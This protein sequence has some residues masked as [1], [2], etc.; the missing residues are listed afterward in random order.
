MNEATGP[1]EPAVSGR[2]GAFTP[3]SP[4]AA[5]G[6]TVAILLLAAA[7]VVAFVFVVAGLQP[8]SPEYSALWIFEH[9]IALFGVWQ[10]IVIL[11]TLWAARWFGGERA[12]VLALGPG[13]P[14]LWTFP[15]ALG[16]MVLV[17]A[18]YNALVYMLSPRSMVADLKP[19][20]ELLQNQDWR[21]LFAVI[22]VGAPLSEELLFRGFLFSA[23]ARSRLRYLGAALITTVAWTSMH[24]GYSIAGL[25]EVFLIGL[26]FSWVLWR[27]GSVWV[28]IFCHAAYNTFLLLVL[29]AVGL[30]A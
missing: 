15:L 6:A 4:W 13:M 24:A 21:V 29:R 22:G 28:T 26:Y 27:T 2:Y 9:Q 25:L 12:R 14:R 23:L 8:S 11:L 7:L 18:P 5:I 1:P 10:I 20:A 3:W 16:G 30:P 19:F 17:V